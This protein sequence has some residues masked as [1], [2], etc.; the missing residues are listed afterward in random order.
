MWKLCFVNF[1]TAVTTFKIVEQ[2]HTFLL[3]FTFTE[4]KIIFMVNN[5]YHF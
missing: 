4:Q 3:I 5:S 1:V 2:K